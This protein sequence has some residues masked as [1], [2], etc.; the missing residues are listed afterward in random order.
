[1]SAQKITLDKLKQFLSEQLG[2]DETEITSDSMLINDLSADSLDVVE[3]VMGLEE[4]Y[5]IEISDDEVETHLEK[6][7]DIW[8]KDVLTLVEKKL[9]KLR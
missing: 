1:M 2:V 4:D 9:G 3:I 8:V 7:G 6:H 5:G